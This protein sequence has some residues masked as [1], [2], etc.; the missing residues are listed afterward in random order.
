M[1]PDRKESTYLSVKTFKRG[2][3]S[4]LFSVR[5]VLVCIMETADL[6]YVTDLICNIWRDRRPLF[7][8]RGAD[9]LAAD[10]YQQ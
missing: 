3:E 9:L 4:Q 2:T 7:P 5:L 6:Y 10:V 1:Y 8:D